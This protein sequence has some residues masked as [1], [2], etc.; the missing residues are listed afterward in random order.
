MSVDVQTE[1]GF[2][3]VANELLEVVMVQKFNGTQFKIIM[4]IWRYTYG[5][6]RKSHE[7]SLTFLS[8]ATG[9]HKQRVKSDLD[10]LIE[11]KI[12]N[13]VSESTFTKSRELSFNKNYDEWIGLQSTKKNTVSESADSTVSE[14]DYT[15][16]SESADQERNI[17]ENNKEN[18]NSNPVS[19]IISFWDSNGFGFN[20]INA[21][22]ELLEYLDDGY[23]KDMLIEAMKIA[24]ERNARHIRF[25][26]GVFRTWSDSNIKTIEDL[27]SREEK[28]SKKTTKEIPREKETYESDS[29]ES[30]FDGS[31]F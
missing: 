16:V 27:K 5:F 6:S 26:R 4:A 24:C 8:N 19:E 11:N 14:S 2:T 15:T 1:H 25:I 13:V 10:K 20:N 12:I 30:S 29:V 22:S 31:L 9:V 17:K 21:K 23:S 18:N 3:R 28:R 7:F